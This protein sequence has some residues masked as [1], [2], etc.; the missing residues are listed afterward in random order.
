[1]RRNRAEIIDQDAFV[2]KNHLLPKVDAAVDFN[3]LY[4]QK[5]IPVA[6]ARC[7]EELLKERNRDGQIHGK[8]E[9]GEERQTGMAEI[10]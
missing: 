9:F 7:R 1:M 10:C 5:K 8:P 6:A 3:S 4:F 2:P